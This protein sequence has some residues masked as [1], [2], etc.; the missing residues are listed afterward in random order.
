VV[1]MDSPEAV[2]SV[3][4]CRRRTTRVI[5]ARRAIV[6]LRRR[7]PVQRRP[8]GRGLSFVRRRHGALGT[9]PPSGTRANRFQDRLSSSPPDSLGCRTVRGLHDRISNTCLAMPAAKSGYYASLRNTH[10][11]PIR[12][13]T[14]TVAPIVREPNA[15]GTR[16]DSGHHLSVFGDYC[17][18]EPVQV[19]TAQVRTSEP[20]GGIGGAAQVVHDRI[21]RGVDSH[22]KD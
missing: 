13:A 22:T 16:C 14:F 5:N 15:P 19:Q 3:A 20:A 11:D 7:P 2:R 9:F 12:I 17:L 8:A 10:R 21:S 18:R 1:V 6:P 4:V